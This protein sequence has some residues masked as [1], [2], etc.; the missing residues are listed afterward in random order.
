MYCTSLHS[1]N[2][3]TLIEYINR[4]SDTSHQSFAIKVVKSI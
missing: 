2:Q 3:Y 4:Q 1:V